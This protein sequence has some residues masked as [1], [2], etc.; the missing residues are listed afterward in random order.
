ML[1]SRR[2]EVYVFHLLAPEDLEP[3][4]AGDLRLIDSEDGDAAEITVSRRLLEKYKQTVAAFNEAVQP[5][6][7]NA[8]IRDGKRAVGIT[9]PKSRKRSRA[10]S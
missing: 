2:M 6:T 9:P 8:A 1:L 4:I 10:A 5:G 3:E 7:F